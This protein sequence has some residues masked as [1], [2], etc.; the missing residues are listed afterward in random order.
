MNKCQAVQLT[1]PYS[2]KQLS[3]LQAE[4]GFSTA[5][6]PL[7]TVMYFYNINGKTNLSQKRFLLRRADK[8]MHVQSHK[9]TTGIGRHDIIKTAFDR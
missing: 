8:C 3:L 4:G 1:E 2:I 6:L 7:T 9:E 5:L